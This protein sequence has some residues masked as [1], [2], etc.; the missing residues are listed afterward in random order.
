MVRKYEEEEKEEGR[1][2]IDELRKRGSTVVASEVRD[3]GLAAGEREE[4]E[5]KENGDYFFQIIKILYL[6]INFI[7][8]IFSVLSRKKNEIILHYFITE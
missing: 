5:R 8:H 6:N 1:V 3:V 4:R 2:V 7:F